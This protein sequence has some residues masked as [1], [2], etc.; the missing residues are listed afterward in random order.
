MYTHLYLRASTKDQDANRAKVALEQFAVEK[1]LDVV[2][3]YAEKREWNEAESPGADATAEHGC[4][5]GCSAG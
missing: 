3:V 4:F 1:Q 5:W 2:G